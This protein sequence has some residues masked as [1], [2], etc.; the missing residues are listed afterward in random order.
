[1]V[2]EALANNHFPKI[3]GLLSMPEI[4][5]DAFWSWLMPKILFATLYRMTV[6]LQELTWSSSESENG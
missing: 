1:L 2:L 6:A 4:H 3:A 5:A